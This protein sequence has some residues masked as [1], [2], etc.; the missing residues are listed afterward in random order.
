M[1]GVCQSSLRNQLDGHAVV[2]FYVIDILLTNA[3]TCTQMKINY[4]W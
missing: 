3:H 2:T 1:C 4:N